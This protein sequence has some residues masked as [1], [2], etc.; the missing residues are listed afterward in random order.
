MNFIE[1]I[2]RALVES[3][4]LSTGL[5]TAVR[6]LFPILAFVVLYRCA[7]SLL[8]F[9]KQPEIWAWLNIDGETSLPVTHWENT[10]GSGQGCDIVVDLDSIGKSHAVLTRYDDGS[11]TISDIGSRGGIEVDGE[12]VSMHAIEYEE[13]FYMGGVP[14]WL[15]RVTAEE[16][17]EQEQ[18]RTKPGSKIKA[19]TTLFYLTVFQIFA[20]L[21]MVLYVGV[22]DISSV[23][24]GYLSLIVLEWGLY[25]FYRLMRRTGYEVETIAFFLCTMGIS[26]IATAD[27]GAMKKEIIIIGMAMVLFL[28][29]GTALRSLERAKKVRYFAAV[30]GIGLLLVNIVF[31]QIQH[32]AR[33]WIMIGSMSFQPSEMVKVC[34][35]FVGASTMDRIVTKR[36]LTLF[37]IY[38]AVICLC[39]AFISDFGAALIFFAAFLVI[40]FLRSGNFAG[41]VMICAAVGFAGTLVLKFRPYVLSR[42]AAW[43]HVWEY[44]TESGGYQQTRSM[45]C[46]A[47]G[48]LFGLGPGRGW[49]KYVAASDTD[50]VFALISEEWGLLIGIMMVLAIVVLAAFVVRSVAVA[51][52]SFYT[53]GACAAVSIFMVQMILNVFGTIDFLPLTG[54]TFPFVSNGGSSMLASWALLGFIKAADTRQN[55]S[56]AI[57]LRPRK[58]ETDE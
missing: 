16:R 35:V 54:V 38:S 40:A 47:S 24:F 48:G 42:F 51:R 44:A 46:I 9:R 22:N 10:I 57:R 2:G 27:P 7:R 12:S 53:I 28:M 49:L 43:G 45:M 26:V 18:T 58:E 36:N 5:L 31:G 56:F 17:K 3:E 23:I 20:M 4:L 6:F 14:F 41:L 50:L 39:L 55:A 52:S 8:T 19:G 32:G 13:P 25:C 34:F 1:R 29:V 33:N 37:I 11:W 30:M 21:I 15:E